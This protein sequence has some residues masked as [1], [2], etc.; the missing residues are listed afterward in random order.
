M[1]SIAENI[2]RLRALVLALGETADPK[3]WRTEFMSET[4]FNFLERLFPRTFFLAAVNGAGKA[5]RDAHDQAIGRVGAYHLF[6]VPLTLELEIRKLT[7]EQ[8]SAIG[9][10]IR[11]LLPDRTKL[12]A[13]LQAA[14]RGEADGKPGPRRMGKVKDIKEADIIGRV[15]SVYNAGFAKGTPVFPYFDVE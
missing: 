8:M 6:R 9:T 1:T 2:I 14:S 5:A 13:A 15:A 3:W 10:E 11:Q 7:P 4:G 12:V